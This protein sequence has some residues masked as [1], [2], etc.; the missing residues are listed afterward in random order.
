M[1]FLLTGVFGLPEY[2]Q[3]D[4]VHPNPDGARVIADN[5]WPCL[6]PLLHETN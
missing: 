5:M 2:N 3:P 4:R 6:A 1:P